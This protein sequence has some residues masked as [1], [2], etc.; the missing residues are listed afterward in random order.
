[1]NTPPRRRRE[2]RERRTRGRR[3]RSI[4]RLPS[5]GV[6]GVFK[7]ELQRLGDNGLVSAVPLHFAYLLCVGVKVDALDRR[8]VGTSLVTLALVLSGYAFVELAA[9]GDYIRLLAPS[10][11]CSYNSGPPPSSPTS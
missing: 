11:V 6:H 10:I 5:A 3:L 4:G 9:P 8:A 1:M 7:G 2:K